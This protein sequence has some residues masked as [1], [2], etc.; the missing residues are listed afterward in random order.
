MRRSCSA[1][2]RI[3]TE[4]WQRVT[5]YNPSCSLG[6]IEPPSITSIIALEAHRRSGR[7][8]VSSP[9]RCNED[10]EELIDPV[11]GDV[12]RDREVLSDSRIGIPAVDDGFECHAASPPAH[13]TPRSKPRPTFVGGGD[14]RELTQ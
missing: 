12:G 13:A 4:A 8:I 1:V 14:T 11:S 9:C 7:S 6:Q 3:R 10:V 5:G 2:P